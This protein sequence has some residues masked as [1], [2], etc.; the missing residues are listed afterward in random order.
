M[1]QLYLT[2]GGRL[3]NKAVF[4]VGPVLRVGGEGMPEG[5]SGWQV[6]W[7]PV[8]TPLVT[9]GACHEKLILVVVT[10]VIWNIRGGPETTGKRNVRVSPPMLRVDVVTLHPK[11]QENEFIITPILSKGRNEQPI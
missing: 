8:S 2:P 7:Y 3:D 1:L 9:A 4:T 11:L 5:S 10:D 6:S